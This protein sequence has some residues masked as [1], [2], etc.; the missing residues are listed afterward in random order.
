[1]V[2]PFQAVMLFSAMATVAVLLFPKSGPELTQLFKHNPALFWKLFFANAIQSGLGSSLS[3][4]GIALTNAINAGFL[5]KLSTVSTIFFAWVILKERMS[6]LKLSVIVI[7][8]SGAY[9]L[10]TKGQAILPQIGDLFILGACLCWSFGNV[11]VRSM[12]RSQSV[13]ADVITI[14]KPLAGT[15]IY[16]I[17]VGF[18]VFYS[19]GLGELG[20][21]LACC[22][23][24]LTFLPYALGSGFCLAMAWIYLY[25]TLNV[26]T[27]SYMTLMSMATP[28]I[29]SILA[30]VILKETLIWIQ[31]I[32]AGLI[33]LSG[34]M[35]YF[36]GI[37][38]A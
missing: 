21:V 34:V 10:T 37:S 28:I 3:I 4:V 12:L 15:P 14:Q 18:S 31:V 32:G 26:A 35:I 9:L 8:L 23:F 25:R 36:S 5:V 17:F 1:M 16:L 24:S 30:M 33:L 22:S 2:L 20:Q 19:D 38:K 13:T 11:I 27:A 29:V 6:F 7:A